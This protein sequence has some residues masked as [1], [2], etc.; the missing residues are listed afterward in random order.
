MMLPLSMAATISA[1]EYRIS[2]PHTHANLSVYLIHGADG[3]HNKFLTLQE[4]LRQHKAIV[5]E[6]GSVNE[7][8]IA[9]ALRPQLLGA[10]AR[11][12]SW[13]GAA[14]TNDRPPRKR[15]RIILVRSYGRNS[16]PHCNVHWMVYKH[17]TQS[18]PDAA[19]GDSA[20]YCLPGYS[21]TGSSTPWNGDNQIKSELG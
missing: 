5:H 7:L 12:R 10:V 14:G 15:A 18:Y 1:A 2:G 8:A 3:T 20:L 11:V 9:H 19:D 13:S 6:T 16:L 17:R 4:A 21:Y